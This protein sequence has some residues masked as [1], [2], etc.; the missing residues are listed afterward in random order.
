MSRTTRRIKS[1]CAVCKKVFEIGDNDK[2]FF[3]NGNVTRTVCESCQ[4]K[5]KKIYGF[6]SKC[7]RGD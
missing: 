4:E 3:D 2:V 5:I 1:V 6:R 7:K